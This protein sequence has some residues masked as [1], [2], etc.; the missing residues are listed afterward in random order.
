MKFN[1]RNIFISS[2]ASIGSNVK[3]G[4]NTCIYDNVEIGDNAIICDNCV[5]G[6]PLKAYYT[7]S[8]YDQPKTKIGSNSL[9]R[10]FSIIYAGCQIGSRLATGHRV[11]I[12]ENTIIGSDC[13]IGTQSDLQGDI[14]IGDY[15]RLHSNVHL[16][17]GSRI[18][19]FVFMY[20]YTVMTNDP[21]PPSEIVR[22]ASIDDYSQI[23]VHTT[24][25]PGVKVGK[26]CLIGA[27]SLVNHHVKDNSLAMGNPIKVI[28]DLTDLKV[29]GVGQYYPWMNNFDRGMP[30]K[31]GEFEEWLAK[32]RNSI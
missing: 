12:R 16:A 3:I 2:T 11:T 15:C 21:N 28:M 10:S 24:L 23:C 29:L 20:P 1:N 17:S 5:I 32:T 25:L 9:I 26:N 18:G 13:S 8:E 4:D 30:W 6:E 19:N 22:G 27:N 31:K 14:I 7:D